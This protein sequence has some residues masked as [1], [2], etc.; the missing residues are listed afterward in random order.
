M[1]SFLYLDEYKMYSISAQLF[2]G[3]TESIVEFSKEERSEN[4][5]QKGPFGSGNLLADIA[6]EQSGKEEK[7]FLHDYAY[8]LFEKKLTEDAKVLDLTDPLPASF[9]EDIQKF[10]FVKVTGQSLFTDVPLMAKLFTEFNTLGEALTYITTFS[11]LADMKEAAEDKIKGVGD[12]NKKA[13]LHEQ[14]KSAANIKKLAKEQGL[15]QDEKFLKNLS[16]VLTYM[17]KDDFEVQL[18]L[19]SEENTSVFFSS[20]LKRNC[21]REQCEAIIRKYGRRCE[22]PLTLFG[23][24]TQGRKKRDKSQV[25]EGDAENLRAAILRI[26]NATASI[27]E[28]FFARLDEEYLIDPVA[29]FRQL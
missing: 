16:Y 23:M 22:E 18:S 17:M 28:T 8:T 5:K 11:K 26:V 10:S 2:G 6:S 15:Q 24:I 12:R 25:E 1:N 29:L 20:P 4:E 13:G 9:P 21:L 19:R 3:L 7:K 14:I 27:E